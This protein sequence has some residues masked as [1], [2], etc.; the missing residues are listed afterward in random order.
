MFLLVFIFWLALLTSAHCCLRYVIAKRAVFYSGQD[1]RV[2]LKPKV[3]P[4]LTV[5]QQIIEVRP[6]RGLSRAGR[7]GGPAFLP[8]LPP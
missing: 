5:Q 3:K 1:F 7:E 2:A 8:C 6:F 4:A